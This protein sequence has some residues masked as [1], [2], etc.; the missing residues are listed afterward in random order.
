MNTSGSRR[1]HLLSK[2]PKVF[3]IPRTDQNLSYCLY[4]HFIK[5]IYNI[6]LIHILGNKTFL[7]LICDRINGGV[8]RK[9]RTASVNTDSQWSKQEACF[10]RATQV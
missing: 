8:K 7:Y 4:L 9:S 6:E 2:R 3:M 10:A 1:P 5:N